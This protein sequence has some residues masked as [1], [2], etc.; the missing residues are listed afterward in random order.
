MEVSMEIQKYDD[1]YYRL[2]KL[3]R[4][5]WWLR[6]L[7]LLLLFVFLVSISITYY[8]LGY[9]HKVNQTQIVKAEKFIVVDE[10]GKTK[11]ILGNIFNE[12]RQSY[13]LGNPY[14][15]ALENKGKSSII[16]N[17]LLLLGQD[18]KT[19]LCLAF[20]DDQSSEKNKEAHFLMFLGPNLKKRIE[21]INQDDESAISIFNE[22][23]EI[24]AGLSY[25]TSTKYKSGEKMR[26]SS[27]YVS[28][29]SSSA[30]LN[31]IYSQLI[32]QSFRIKKSI[33]GEYPS[34]TL[35]CNK[36]N[37]PGP[38]ISLRINEGNFP[39][40]TMEK[41]TGFVE[42]KKAEFGHSSINE[43]KILIGF[44]D[45]DTP[46]IK[47]FDEKQQLRATIGSADLVKKT[48]TKIKTPLSSMVF[49]NEKGN[50]IWKAPLE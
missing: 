18:D 7:W 50:V 29:E 45:S 33:F 2:G 15:A 4:Q 38:E 26:K 43:G 40:L 47:L 5:N 36:L 11:A 27:I 34:L 14:E 24:R 8:Y 10:Q 17:G 41:N 20:G 25:D 9:T 32:N 13:S 35:S 39:I 30:S 16:V 6:I 48:G 28:G 12:L 49:F 21:I 42:D 31:V 1:L 46:I 19:R 23:E 44:D 37:K 22:N 3:E